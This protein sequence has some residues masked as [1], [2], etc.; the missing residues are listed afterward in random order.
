LGQEVVE[1]AEVV[2]P[3]AAAVVALAVDLELVLMALLTEVTG[4]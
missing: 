1:V 4:A 3:E 2:A